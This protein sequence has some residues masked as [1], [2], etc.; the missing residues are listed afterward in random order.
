[1]SYRQRKSEWRTAR[2]RRRVVGHVQ[3][4]HEHPLYS[5]EN[6]RKLGKFKSETGNVLPLEYVGKQMYSLD[7]S[8]GIRSFHKANGVPK[9]YVRN[10]VRHNQC[11]DILN[12]WKKYELRF[13]HVQVE[14]VPSRHASPIQ[15]LPV[16][17]QRQTIFA[18][19]LDTLS[20]IRTLRNIAGGR[21]APGGSA[22]NYSL[23]FAFCRS[24]F[25]II[26]FC[27]QLIKC[28]V[29]CI[30]VFRLLVR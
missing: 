10:K 29:A 28:R 5:E 30:F 21:G 1:M 18:Q 4:D 26:V 16:V 22:T 25:V 2:H 8:E 11:I 23:T 17:H 12:H 13:P 14:E 7:T 20:R 9:S 19:R 27:L 3:F 6:H 15:S 24:F